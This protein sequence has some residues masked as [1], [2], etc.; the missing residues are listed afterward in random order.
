ML[1]IDAVLFKLDYRIHILG[2]VSSTPNISSLAS[3]AEGP[4][5]RLA[6]SLSS[7]PPRFVDNVP[8]HADASISRG[9]LSLTKLLCK[10]IISNVRC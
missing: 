3:H 9:E 7:L 8:Q 2:A 1:G 10:R 6:P 5:S 4:E